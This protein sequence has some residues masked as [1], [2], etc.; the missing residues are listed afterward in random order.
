MIRVMVLVVSTSNVWRLQ[1][2][3]R[4]LRRGPQLC[5]QEFGLVSDWNGKYVENV[6]GQLIPTVS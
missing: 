6:T 2:K 4:R 5:Q 3:K 1:V